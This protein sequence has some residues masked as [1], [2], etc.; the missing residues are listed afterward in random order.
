MTFWKLFLATEN[1]ENFFLSRWLAQLASSPFH[2]PKAPFILPLKPDAGRHRATLLDA[3]RHWAT[4]LDAGQH[5]ATLNNT[6]IYLL[7]H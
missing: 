4:L 7:V 5:M 1:S 2:Q 6:W 3:G